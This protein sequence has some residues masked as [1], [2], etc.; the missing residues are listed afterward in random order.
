MNESTRQR[1]FGVGEAFDHPF[2]LWATVSIGALLVFSLVLVVALNKMGKLSPAHYDELMKRIFSWCVIAPV[3]VVPILMG[4][5]WVVL[6]S[7]V[8]GLMCYR[9]YAR[10]TGLFR[11]FAISALF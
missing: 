2:T 8:L 4:A 7:T 6:G 5:F 10:A 11:H 9:E 1:L 3:L